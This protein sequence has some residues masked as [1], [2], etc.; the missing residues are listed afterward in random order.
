MCMSPEELA[1]GGELADGLAE[2]LAVGGV[3]QRRL[4]GRLRDADA[5]AGD[6]QAGAVHQVHDVGGEAAPAA[7]DELGGGVVEL[8]LAGGRAVDAELVLDAADAHRR[9]GLAR[10]TGS[11]RARPRCLP[12]CGPAPAAPRAQPLVMKRLTPLRR[13]VSVA[14]SWMARSWTL[15]RSLPASGSVRTMAPVTSPE[16]NLGRYLSLSASSAKA[17]MVSA[18]SCR[19][20]RF[21]RLASAR[22]TISMAMVYMSDGHV[23]AAVPARQRE[24]HQVG[25]ARAASRASW[26]PLA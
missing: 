21:I 14:S 22:L 6:A 23:Q 18:M 20:K 25:L 19:P 1:H 17:W 16:E 13:H 9:A 2:L 12:R 10:G 26:V 7:A 8:D 11:G 5:L 4:E 24:A 15:P 3:V